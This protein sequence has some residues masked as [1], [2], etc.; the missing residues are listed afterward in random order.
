MDYCIQT[1]GLS[2]HFKG[3]TALK[4]VNMNVK[5]GEIY[6]FLGPNGAGKS[7]VFK[8]LMALLKPDAGKI[9]RQAETLSQGLNGF[10]RQTGS[11]IEN[12]YFY[13][14]LSGYENLKIHARYMGYYVENDAQTKIKD[15]LRLVHLSDT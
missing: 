13:E 9:M 10:F 1:Q 4:S 8:L 2:K 15:I 6:G 3:V 5:L 12:P 11:I 14:D 7:T